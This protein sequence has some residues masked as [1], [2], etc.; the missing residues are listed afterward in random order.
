[1]NYKIID[2]FLEKEKLEFLQKILF[3]E[4]TP[5]YYRDSMT[6]PRNNTEHAFYNHCIYNLKKPQSNLFEH[7]DVFIEKLNIVALDEIRV[8]SMYVQKDHYESKWHTDRY[9]KC[10]TGIF[11]LN[12]CNGH[13][14]LKTNPITKIESIENRMLIFDSQIEHKVISQTDT[15]RRMVIN[16]NYFDNP[17]AF[18][19]N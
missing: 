9:F 17:C 11:Y 2:N 3:S 8:N 12:T 1:M 14:L 7:M 5:W 13:T 4:G 18:N 10:K 16:F 19:N 15:K 6:V